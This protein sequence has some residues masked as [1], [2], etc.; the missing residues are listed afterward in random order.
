MGWEG[1]TDLRSKKRYEVI[2]SERKNLNLLLMCKIRGE[3]FL[4][5]GTIE[6]VYFSN[7]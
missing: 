5:S 6:A 2:I 4:V 1:D 7:I 3:K